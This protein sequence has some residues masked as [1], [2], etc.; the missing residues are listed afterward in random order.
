VAQQSE[1]TAAGA[2]PGHSARR[3]VTMRYDVLIFLIGF[4]LGALCVAVFGTP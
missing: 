2:C 1:S 4:L 3:G